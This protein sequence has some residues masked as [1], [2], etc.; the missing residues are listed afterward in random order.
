M[1]LRAIRWLGEVAGVDEPEVGGKAANL[2][3]MTEAGFSVPPGF[4][5]TAPAY[6]DALDQLGIRKSLRALV[7][8][9]VAGR[10]LLADVSSRA[11]LLILNAGL[12]SG[13]TSA[14]TDS[15]E[16]LKEKRHGVTP[17]VVA[18][19]SSAT[20]ED[21]EATSFA[22]VN[23]SFTNMVTAEEV[24]AAIVQCW[25]SLY[26]ERAL[27]YRNEQGISGEPAMAVH[28]QVRR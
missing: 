10:L 15:L 14:V 20:G 24:C 27:V 18:V 23:E 25:A 16:Q 1:I 28:H 3:E 19:R 26:S 6:L 5:V 9:H 21:S 8:D 12:P 22:G 2:G 11:R 7:R 4:V 13:L 17:L